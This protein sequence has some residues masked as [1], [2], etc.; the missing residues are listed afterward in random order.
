M[1]TASETR[2][3]RRAS[4]EA[5]RLAAAAKQRRFRIILV[6]SGVIVL[7]VVLV[8]AIIAIIGAQNK[9]GADVP[10]NANSAKNG[11]WLKPPTEGAPTLDLFSDYNCTNCKSAELV[12]DAQLDSL[13]DEGKVN[14]LV[15]SMQFEGATSRIAA[16]AAACADYSGNFADY[17]QQLFI[18][19][20]TDGS[21]FTDTM[22]RE[23]IPA[24]IGIT[25]S[26]LTQLQSC[27]DTTATGNFVDAQDKYAN[28]QGVSRTPTFLLDGEDIA[29]KIF[30]EDTG[31]YDADLLRQV[32]E[33]A[34]GQ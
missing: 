21:G 6:T 9:G 22:L 24:N 15:H 12:L 11:I 31:S 18:N 5:Q 29:S 34:D 1:P 16:V 17:N 33:A 2:Q 13:T 7:A 32:V 20:S 23:T 26:D 4:L 3:S 27:I 10:P 19:Q 25:G 8:I 30:N 14:V 28:Q